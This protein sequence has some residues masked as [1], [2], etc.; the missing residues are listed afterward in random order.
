MNQSEVDVY[1]TFIHVEAVF[2]VS[3]DFRG[4][5]LG[6]VWDVPGRF[7]VVLERLGASWCGLRRLGASWTCFGG[8]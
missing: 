4:I 5:F 2:K 7:G 6:R 8:V 3:C 1:F